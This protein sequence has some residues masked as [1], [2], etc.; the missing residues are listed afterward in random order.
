MQYHNEITQYIILICMESEQKINFYLNK[1]NKKKDILLKISKYNSYKSQNIKGRFI[2]SLSHIQIYH[3]LIL[4]G[5]GLSIAVEIVIQKSSDIVCNYL[6]I[7]V[8]SCV[9]QFV[10]VILNAVSL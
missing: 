3:G 8:V 2:V 6:W 9:V 4:V 5:C 10:V 7:H 1:K